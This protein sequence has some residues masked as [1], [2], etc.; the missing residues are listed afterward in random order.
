MRDATQASSLNLHV[1]DDAEEVARRVAARF[2]EVA[3]ESVRERGSFSVALAGGSTPRGVY[4]LL[5]SDPWRDEDFW[6]KTHVFFG[7][8]RAVPPD[9]ADSN[10][11][12]VSETLLARLPIPPQNIHRMRGEGDATANASLYED[13]L[14]SFFG[15]VEWPRF[16]LVMLGMGE[17]G[18][19]ASLFPSTRALR[20]SGAWAS[21]NWV[22]KLHAWRITLTAKA[23]NHARHVLFVVTG[24]AKAEALAGVL[25]GRGEPEQLPARFIQPAG[26]LE[27][28]IDHAAAGKLKE[29]TT[30]GASEE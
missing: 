23:I 11:R 25:E 28:F 13:E 5:A 22:D 27:W 24:A 10:Y 16:D 19:T 4:E 1:C 2:A 8:E 18:H 29:G 9:H 7:D 21:A 14:R 26:T 30:R 15:E 6:P 3:R 17:D 12:M 20:E